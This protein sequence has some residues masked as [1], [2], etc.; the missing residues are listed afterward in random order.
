MR[1]VV[2]VG[3]AVT[4]VSR[5][6]DDDKRFERNVCQQPKEQRSVNLVVHHG[7]P[8]GMPSCDLVCGGGGGTTVWAGPLKGW[9]TCACGT[10][11]PARRPMTKLNRPTTKFLVRIAT[12]HGAGTFISN[13]AVL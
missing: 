2:G 5:E 3:V 7:T 10:S 11:K 13:G 1:L 12:V 6:A 9:N 8:S 4:A